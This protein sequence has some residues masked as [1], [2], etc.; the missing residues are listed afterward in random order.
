MLCVFGS[1]TKTCERISKKMGD[2]FGKSANVQSVK[3]ID[4]DSLAHELED[5]SILKENFDVIVVCT[6]SFGDG[7]PP[8][9]Y[10]KFLLALLVGATEGTKPL[11]GMQ[12]AVLGEGSSVYQETFQ[13]CPRL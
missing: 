8:D 12:H 11:A 10:S 3:V 7:D 2:H 5:L 9:N 1:Q 13:N 6:S 4:G